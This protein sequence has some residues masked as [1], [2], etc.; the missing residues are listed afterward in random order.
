[1][2]DQWKLYIQC[3]ELVLGVQCVSLKNEY[4]PPPAPP[5]IQLNN[6]PTLEHMHKCSLL[7]RIW[8][9]AESPVRNSW[10]C[11]YVF[12]CRKISCDRLKP[13]SK[14]KERW[15]QRTLIT[16]QSVRLGFSPTIPVRGRGSL[17]FLCRALKLGGINGTW[18]NHKCQE[19]WRAA[20]NAATS[21]HPGRRDSH[22][23]PL[24]H[25]A[26]ASD[27]IA[28]REG[29]LAS[30]QGYHVHAYDEA[31]WHA[32]E[33][34]ILHIVNAGVIRNLPISFSCPDIWTATSSTLRHQ[35]CAKIIDDNDLNRYQFTE[36]LSYIP[37]RAHCFIWLI[38]FHPHN[39]SGRK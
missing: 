31:D 4:L 35:L 20:Q 10:C 27:K 36:H 18:L 9:A 17:W 12:P 2:N 15:I 24:L 22:W 38:S 16:F 25:S 30:T 33:N 21:I 6:S 14:I 11:L 5:P 37:H 32:N 28:K 3:L 39:L 13:G 29:T 26:W 23:R 1:M 7:G 34:L 8:E 19:V